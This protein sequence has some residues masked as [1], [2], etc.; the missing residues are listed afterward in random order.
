MGM[1]DFNPG[2]AHSVSGG[3][4]APVPFTSIPIPAMPKGNSLQMEHMKLRERFKTLTD[5]PKEIRDTG[6][7]IGNLLLF[8]LATTIAAILINLAVL[9]KMK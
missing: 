8:V 6:E 2:K 7:R 1:A 4:N 5:A 3:Q 9:V